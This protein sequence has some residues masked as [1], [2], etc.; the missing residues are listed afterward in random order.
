MSITPVVNR[1]MPLRDLIEAMLGVT[2]KDAPRIRE[3]LLRGSVVQGGS[4]FRW[5]ALDADAASI[6]ALLACFPDADATKAF[7]PSA[8]F[9]LVLRGCRTVDLPKELVA[10][11]RLFRSSSFWDVLMDTAAR[12]QLEYAGYSYRDKADSYRGVLDA[13]AA[14]RLEAEARLLKYDG[15]RTQVA[16]AEAHTIEF[17]VR[18]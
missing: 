4:R 17:L 8:C 7:S 16:R 3:I 6:G 2:G 11:K 18:R 9:H 15:L 14:A 1:S 13:S 12:L 5:N 10:R